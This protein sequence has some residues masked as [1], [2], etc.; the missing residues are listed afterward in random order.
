VIALWSLRS[1]R[2]VFVAGLLLIVVNLLATVTWMLS[3]QVV[4]GTI[5]HLAGLAFLT[6]TGAMAVRVILRPGS[7]DQNKIIG[8]LCVYLLLGIAWAELCQ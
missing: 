1:S 6:V 7:V 8:A 4:A 3:G 5:A 2:R